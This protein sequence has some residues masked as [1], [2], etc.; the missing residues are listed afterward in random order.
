M[1]T[2]LKDDTPYC[3]FPMS[4]RSVGDRALW[5]QMR[6]LARP[7]ETHLGHVYAIERRIEVSEA[8]SLSF[9]MYETGYWRG[10]P[11]RRSDMSVASTDLT[12]EGLKR[13]SALSLLCAESDRYSGMVFRSIR[14]HNDGV[15]RA[16]EGGGAAETACSYVCLSFWGGALILRESAFSGSALSDDLVPDVPG[17]FGFGFLW[18]E[19]SYDA[20]DDARTDAD[21]LIGKYISDRL[22]PGI[23]EPRPLGREF[24]VAIEVKDHAVS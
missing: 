10:F 8:G 24:G 7:K 19:I 1:E 18:R 6:G 5:R 12:V 15:L 11:G 21:I 9:N 17:G 13:V 3:S 23:P 22:Y 2:Y 4:I 20:L 16:R 14:E